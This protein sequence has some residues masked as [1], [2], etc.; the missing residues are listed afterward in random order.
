MS[1]QKILDWAIKA[2]PGE[3][4]IYHKGKQLSNFQNLHD[5]SDDVWGARYCYNV[6]L[7][8]LKQRRDGR[9]FFYIAQKKSV[10]SPPEK[11]YSVDGHRVDRFPIPTR[12]FR[13]G[14]NDVSVAA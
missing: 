2:A 9:L 6:G 10:Q 7:V 12:Y 11:A 3:E 1:F 8:D 5:Y 4:L 13:N 14:A